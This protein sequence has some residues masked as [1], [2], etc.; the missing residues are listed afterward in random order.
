MFLGYFSKKKKKV[1]RRFRKSSKAALEK[2][3]SRNKKRVK[4]GY[5]RTTSWNRRNKVVG[6]SPE[7]WVSPVD[8]VPYVN[9]ANK[10]YRVG[11]YSR[12]GY[13]LVKT[14][15]PVRK[16]R[17]K[18]IRR[19]KR[20]YRY[21]KGVVERTRRITFPKKGRSRSSPRRASP[22]YKGSKYEYRKYRR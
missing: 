16:Y 1:Y 6:L 21:R 10:T 3:Y 5:K 9:V 8:F 4:R 14:S 15:K 17:K 12:K 13:K 2:S 18:V 19:G 7:N 22:Y 11:K 20:V